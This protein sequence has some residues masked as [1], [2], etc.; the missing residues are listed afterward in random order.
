MQYENE[1]LGVSFNVP[2]E[3]PVRKQLA[4]KSALI[5]YDD[6]SH[7]R[8]YERLWRAAGVVIDGWKCEHVK[9]A[10]DLDK[11]ANAKAAEVIEW[12]ALKVSA[13]MR[14]LGSVPKN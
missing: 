11:V 14:E 10:D 13:H 3:M 1:A 7:S 6:D 4:Y 2:D 8:F 5:S 12:A 9:P